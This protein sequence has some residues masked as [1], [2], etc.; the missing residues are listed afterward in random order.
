MECGSPSGR[1]PGRP[2]RRSLPG[3]QPAQAGNPAA[4]PGRPARYVGVQPRRAGRAGSRELLPA[5]RVL[6]RGL[7]PRAIL[8]DFAEDLLSLAPGLNPACWADSLGRR[9]SLEVAWHSRDPALAISTGLHWLLPNWCD[10]NHRQQLFGLGIG[11][12]FRNRGRRSA[13]LR[14]QLEIQ[15]RGAGGAP[16]VCAGRTD[17]PANEERGSRIR[18]M[19]SMSIGCCARPRPSDPRLL[20]LDAVDS[21]RR[22]SSSRT[23]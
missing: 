17:S 20:D 13:R 14:A 11:N 6:E 9:E 21:R 7:R 15:S 4:H 1:W 23:A 12:G 10:Q 3:R 2:R 19:L 16:R 18:R 22:D 5:S 8:V